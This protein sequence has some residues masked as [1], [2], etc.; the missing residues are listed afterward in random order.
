MSENF[1]I[2]MRNPYF[3]DTS[4]IME[5]RETIVNLNAGRILCMFC[6]KNDKHTLF[7]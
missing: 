3:C 6:K 5:C 4:L 7:K 2:A 1:E